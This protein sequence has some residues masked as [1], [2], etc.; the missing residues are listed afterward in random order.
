MIPKQS[1]DISTLF[2]PDVTAETFTDTQLEPPKYLTIPVKIGDTHIDVLPEA[3]PLRGIAHSSYSSHSHASHE[4]YFIEMGT[5]SL[6]CDGQ[7][8]DLNTG[9]LFVIRARTPHHIISCSSDLRR[10]NVRFLLRSHEYTDKALKSYLH[11]SPS[12]D[13]KQEILD[14]MHHVRSL[15]KKDI[16]KLELFRLKSHYGILFSY[17]LGFFCED[18]RTEALGRYS[19]LTLYSRIESYFAKNCNSQITL[20]SLA[21][22]LSYSKAQTNRILHECY[23]SSFSQILRNTRIVVAKRLLAESTLP[24]NEIAAR[25]GYDTRQGFELMFSKYVGITPHA[26]REEN[27][28]VHG[29]VGMQV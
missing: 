15:M 1:D 23:G 8:V 10:F 7:R 11:Y 29:T 16:G 13:E 9:D 12:T 20:E 17:A 19:R 28:V 6:E 26:F 18:D 27:N 4:T 14:S 22:Y 25:C 5:L 24:I 2:V 3:S 21:S